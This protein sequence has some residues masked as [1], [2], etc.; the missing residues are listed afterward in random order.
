MR[1]SS[2]R[3]AGVVFPVALLLLASSVGAQTTNR[4]AALSPKAQAQI[5]SVRRAMSR[6]ADPRVAEDS[7]YQPVFGMVPLQGV[8]YVRPDL[9]R[10]GTFDLTEPSVLMYA[11][12][13]RQARARGSRVRVRAS[14]IE[15]DPGGVRRSER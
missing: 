3:S 6:F 2:F 7:G 9:V 5:D 14:A 4:P 15:A 11:P 8:H 13:E 1:R 10:D 12:V